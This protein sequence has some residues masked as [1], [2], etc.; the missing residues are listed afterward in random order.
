MK[1]NSPPVGESWALLRDFFFW[2]VQLLTLQDRIKNLAFG[3]QLNVTDSLTIP[4][5][6]KILAFVEQLILI[7]ALSIPPN[8]QKNLPGR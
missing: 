5:K 6:T 3:E 4:P 7:D 1:H 8:A 2:L